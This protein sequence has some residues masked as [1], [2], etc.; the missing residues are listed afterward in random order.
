MEISN[1]DFSNLTWV[2]NLQRGFMKIIEHNY[3]FQKIF[4]EICIS[5]KYHVFFTLFRIQ[6]N[7]FRH[8]NNYYNNL[9]KSNENQYKSLVSHA[10]YWWKVKIIFYINIIIIASIYNILKIKSYYYF[11]LKKSF[12]KF[13]L[14]FIVNK[15]Y[16]IYI[17][18]NFTF[19]TRIIYMIIVLLCILGKHRMYIIFIIRINLNKWKHVNSSFLWMP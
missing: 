13:I 16:Y 19:K 1:I 7:Q 3:N 18:I 4:F 11:I 17:K 12:F 14:K 5:E 8:N 15:K 10:I 6:D 9:Y 2:P